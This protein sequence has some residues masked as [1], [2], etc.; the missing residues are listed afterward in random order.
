[1][2]FIDI[3]IYGYFLIKKL[4]PSEIGDP[5]SDGIPIMISLIFNAQCI[6]AVTAVNISNFTGNAGR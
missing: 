1:M 5:V 6:D 4:M 3:G 2:I